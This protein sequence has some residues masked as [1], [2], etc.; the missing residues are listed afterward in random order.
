MSKA[1][2]AMRISASLALLAALPAGAQVMFERQPERIA[3]E[4]DG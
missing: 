1:M 2:F 4:I 3:V